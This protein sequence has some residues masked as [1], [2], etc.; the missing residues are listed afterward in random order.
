MTNLITDH[1]GPLLVGADTGGTF[2]DLVVCDRDGLIVHATK[3]STT[4]G[5]PSEALLEAFA[6]TAV[7]TVGAFLHGTT[8]G[9]NT[10]LERRGARTALLTTQGFRDILELARQDRPSLY[11]PFQEKPRP[12]V[13][14]E[15]CFEIDER[16]A[17]VPEARRA[18]NEK[19]ARSVM[20][21]LHE[22]GVESVAVSLLHAYQDDRHERRLQELLAAALPHASVSLSSEVLPEIMEYERT[23]TTVANAYLALVM[24]AYLRRL[25]SGLE[26]TGLVAPVYVMQSNGGLGAATTVARRAVQTV[27]SGPAAG[28]IGG[29]ASTAGS[30]KSNFLTI[31]MGGTSFD[32]AYAEG[33]QPSVSRESAIDGLPIALPSLDI[34]TLGAGGGSIAWIDRGGALR[35][36]PRSA[37]AMPGPACYGRGGDQPTVTDANVVLGRLGSE[38]LG[39]RLALDVDAAHRTIERCVAKPLGWSIVDAA[40]GI[41]A[42]VNGS[43]AKGMHLKSV[44]RGRD[45]RTLGI[46]GFG[47]AGPLHACDLAVALGTSEVIVPLLPGNTSAI[48][49][50]LAS[51]RRERSQVVLRPLDGFSQ[52]EAAG[53]LDELASTVIA[54]LGEDGVEPRDLVLE[55]I[56]RVSYDGQRYQID[57][58]VSTNG[59]WSAGTPFPGSL[60]SVPEGFRQRH[61]IAYGYTREEPLSL[62]GLVVVGTAAIGSARVPAMRLE[63]DSRETASPGMRRVW[64]SDEF[65]DTP[66]LQRHELPVGEKFEGPA[67]VE[68][69]D[70]TTVVP[71][72]WCGTIDPYGNLILHLG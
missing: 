24:E 52:T 41:V 71:P 1:R 18:L 25:L 45:P 51:V 10:L 67:V 68:Q 61:R 48:G 30:A 29:L 47:G 62:F 59:K 8:T 72:G 6:G 32:I 4:P 3:V 66:I 54:A 33:R 22:L 28:V 44:A 64:F 17:P 5:D 15:L 37:G 39:G 43:M 9:T 42:V 7:D 50:A 49:L 55:A 34:H 19:Q 13:P 36:G 31:D 56:A 53:L 27:L 23:S 12:L 14:R 57:V 65:H 46:V 70:S 21:Q 40:R 38:L 60:E 58:P 63:R 16:Q 26:A 2:T 35:V 69:P 20:R 11:D